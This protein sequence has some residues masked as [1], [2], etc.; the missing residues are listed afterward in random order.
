MAT[1]GSYVQYGAG[2]SGPD[3]WLHF[4]CSPTLRVQRLPLVGPSI[5]ACC[6]TKFDDAIRYGDIVRGL[7][8]QDRSARAVYCSH[9]LEHL[10]L[11][12]LRRAL[13]NTHRILMPG[14]TFRMVLPDLRHLAS[15]YVRNDS[16]DAAIEFMRETRLGAEIRPRG[17]MGL[18]RSWLGNS[19][20][21]WLWD[22]QSLSREL[23]DAG[24]KN[25]RRVTFNDSAD[26]KFHAAER[27]DRWLNALGIEC[28]A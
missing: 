14:G 21:L 24:F 9:V 23:V 28:T 8:V 3:G 2:A 7:P 13:R 16:S 5:R 20:H 18:L 17:L 1:A 15:E 22:F 4:D 19:E 27:A 26:P 10:S 25:P 6:R 11:A 12:D